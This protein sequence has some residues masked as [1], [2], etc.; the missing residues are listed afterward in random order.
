[1]GLSS[2]SHTA[3]RA[4]EELLINGEQSY[5]DKRR[6]KRGRKERMTLHFANY[7]LYVSILSYQHSLSKNDVCMWQEYKMIQPSLA[8]SFVRPHRDEITPECGT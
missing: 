6:I 5:N 1:M 7:M 8:M 2:S 4:F 3:D